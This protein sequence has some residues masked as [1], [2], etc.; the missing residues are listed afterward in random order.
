MTHSI[1]LV[2]GGVLGGL[3]ISNLQ[4]KKKLPGYALLSLSIFLILHGLGV[5]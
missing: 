2:V 3:S 4:S 1:I 5:I